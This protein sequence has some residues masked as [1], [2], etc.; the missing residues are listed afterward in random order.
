MAFFLYV[1]LYA[2][3]CSVARALWSMILCSANKQSSFNSVAST[4]TL[5]GENGHLR[6]PTAVT[7]D[8]RLYLYVTDQFKE[9]VQ[10]MSVKLAPDS[11]SLRYDSHVCLS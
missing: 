5:G 1:T 9:R 11:I 2:I 7:L 10:I 8:N 6:N 3:L 4:R